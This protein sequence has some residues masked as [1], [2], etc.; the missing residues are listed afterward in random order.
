M[1]VRPISPSDK[2]TTVMQPRYCVI[3]M[4]ALCLGALLAPVTL[5]AQPARFASPDAAVAALLHA[6]AQDDPAALQTI[7]GPAGKDLVRSGD[8]VA[9]QA[10][11][12]ALVTHY[13]AGHSVMYDGTRRAYLILGA[14]AW[15]FPI[16][17]VKSHGAWH[18]DTADGRQ[19]ILN[20]RIG[21]DE[22]RA[23]KICHGFVEAE[24]QFA[25]GHPSPLY[26][27]KIVSAQGQQDGL[28][29]PVSDGG[30]PS[31][32]GPDMARAVAEGY[33]PSGANGGQTP[34]H[35][36]Y[37][38]IL[39]SQGPSAPGGARQYIV[40]GRM[41]GGFALVGYPAKYGDSGVMTFIVNQNGIVYQKD[42]GPQT[43]TLGQSMNS[44]DPDAGWQ[45]Q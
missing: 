28:F 18:W 20:R 40:D 24:Q 1:S 42:L 7:Y 38:H 22:L 45:P 9:D 17:L 4:A 8:P 31:P 25:A 27:A 34:Y 10:N 23:I 2:D 6:A 39:T 33:Q 19:E 5:A 44:F 21:R 14:D 36:Y 30:A 16:P 3:K 26:A 43:H 37:F 15:P 12:K 29:W 32:L 13:T 35:G 11:N 41:T